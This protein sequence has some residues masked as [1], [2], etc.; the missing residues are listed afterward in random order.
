MDGFDWPCDPDDAG[1]VVQPKRFVVEQANGTLIPDRR[2]VRD[3]EI[4]VR[5]A[6]SR[7]LGASA[8]NMTRR[9]TGT[10]TPTWRTPGQQEA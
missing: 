4:D 6:E 7:V 1:F 9:L 10:N 8:A 3:Y 5:S 2:L